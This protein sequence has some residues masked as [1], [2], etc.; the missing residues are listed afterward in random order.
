MFI[1]LYYISSHIVKD[2]IINL[3]VYARGVESCKFC[4]LSIFGLMFT[5]LL[6]SLVRYLKVTVFIQNTLYHLELYQYICI[7]KD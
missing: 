5:L 2:L 1:F 6:D 4:V 7:K 3:W